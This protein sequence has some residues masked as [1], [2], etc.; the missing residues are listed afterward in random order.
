MLFSPSPLFAC[1]TQKKRRD[2]VPR[3]WM[4]LVRTQLM[5]AP[6]GVLTKAF[7]LDIAQLADIVNT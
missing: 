5:E 6:S 4:S 7:V 2:L 1:D 3:P